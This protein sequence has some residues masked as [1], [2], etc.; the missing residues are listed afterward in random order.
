M[1]GNTRKHSIAALVAILM[2][3]NVAPAMGQTTDTPQVRYRTVEIDGLDI[4]YRE[5]GDPGSPAI[6]LLYGFPTSSHMFRNLMPALADQYYLVAPDYPGFGNSEQPPMDEFDYTFDRLAEVVWPNP[7][8]IKALFP[9]KVR[10][11]IRRNSSLAA[12]SPRESR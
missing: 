11:L 12:R 7:A 2:G 8:P 4:F 10:G 5:A 1:F 9:C 3:L 6:P